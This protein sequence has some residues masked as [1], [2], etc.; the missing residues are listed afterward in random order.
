MKKTIIYSIATTLLLFTACNKDSNNDNGNGNGSD[1]SAFTADGATKSV[2]SVAEG[3]TVRFSR[4]NLQYN[5]AQGS[6]ATADGQTLQGTWR[7]ALN[8][9]DTVTNIRNASSSFDGWISH[10]AWGTSGWN[11]GAVYYNPWMSGHIGVDESFFRSDNY[12]PGGDPSVSL[13]GSYVNADWAYFNAISNGGNHPCMW[14]TLTKD[15][16]DFLLRDRTTSTVNNT[17]NARFAPSNIAGIEGVILFPDTY[18]HP[19][20]VALPLCINKQPNYARDSMSYYSIPQWNEMESAGCV[21]LPVRGIIN[22][23]SSTTK[24]EYWSTT[25]SPLGQKYCPWFLSFT[26]YDS[27]NSSGVFV[28]SVTTNSEYRIG[29]KVRPVQDVK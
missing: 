12:W 24:G 22:S 6:H 28:I 16:W 15:E 20:N 18:R 25:S 29:R 3:R 5:A 1:N 23:S 7:F 27:S 21:F 14:R 10:F 19:S 11:S 13:S 2:F 9:Y 17:P 26:F 8:Q 4:G